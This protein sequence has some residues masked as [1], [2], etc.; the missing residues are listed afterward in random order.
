[1]NIITTYINKLE[2]HYEKLFILIYSCIVGIFFLGTTMISFELPRGTSWI[3]LI[4]LFGLTCVC[5]MR[6]QD[7]KSQIEYLVICMVFSISGLISSYHELIYVGALIVAASNIDFDKIILAYLS[8]TIPFLI[9]TVIGSQIGLIENLVYPHL[10]RGDRISYGFISP[11]DFGAH[12]LFILLAIFSIVKN[13]KY[14]KW[15][16]LS[17][18][19]MFFVYKQCDGRTTVLSIAIFLTLF[20]IYY[21]IKNW[22]NRNNTIFFGVIILIES[23]IISISF[24]F[25]YLYRFGNEFI[26]K[27]NDI[28]SDRLMYISQTMENYNISM[29]G[30]FIEEHGNGRSIIASDNYFFIDNSFVKNL[31]QYGILVFVLTIIIIFYAQKR[32]MEKNEYVMCIAV[33]VVIIASFIEHHLIEIAYNPFLLSVFAC[34]NTIDDKTDVEEKRE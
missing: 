7:R 26:L 22:I 13:N 1:M 33:L 20:A 2:R 17:F 6:E 11:T 28:V 19:S 9:I 29:F 31:Y 27:I 18:V 12:I 4:L 23:M 5:I 16:I 15:I 30:Q 3:F 10:Y 24:L 21:I 25:G 14:M 32:M 34:I 8:V